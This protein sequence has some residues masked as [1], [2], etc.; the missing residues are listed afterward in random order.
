MKHIHQISS[1]I[2][3]TPI[4]WIALI[5]TICPVKLSAQSYGWD[6]SIPFA[7]APEGEFGGAIAPEFF[8]RTLNGQ[9]VYQRRAAIR[10]GW[11]PKQSFTVWGEGGVG[12]LQL[13]EA[14]RQLLGAWGPAAGGGW[15]YLWHEPV[16]KGWTPFGSGRLTYLQ[17]KLSDDVL[18]GNTVK[19]RRSRFDWMEYSGVI[20]AAQHRLWGDIQT[21]LT[22]RML[23]Q[24]EYRSFRTSTNVQKSKTQYSSGLQPGIMI[25][26]SVIL[27]HRMTLG[28]S[29]ELSANY[30]ALTVCFGQWGKP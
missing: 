13:F 22:L 11:T 16:W 7:L 2:F 21:G 27:S 28:I 17:S 20:G 9:L 4:L 24:D 25:G 18:V 5:L 8:R 29:S 3:I 26:G 10:M 1:A 19:S 23:N 12:S 6:V 15:S 30:L 14:D